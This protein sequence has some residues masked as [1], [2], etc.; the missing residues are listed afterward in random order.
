[1]S[2]LP[3]M[4]VLLLLIGWKDLFSAAKFACRGFMEALQMEIIQKGLYNK[5][6]LTSV[7]PYFVKTG[8]IENLEE[9]YS[10]YVAHEF[11]CAH[12]K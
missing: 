11:T 3:Q 8:L 12:A 5:I 9:P 10:T 1:M 4:N 7:F 6:V 2:A